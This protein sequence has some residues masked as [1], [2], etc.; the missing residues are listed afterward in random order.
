MTW[1]IWPR[2]LAARR[3]PPRRREEG[4][5]GVR[6]GKEGRVVTFCTC[7]TQNPSGGQV[8]DRGSGNSPGRSV[9]C[10]PPLDG[11]LSPY[12]PSPCCHV[13]YVCLPGRLRIRSP[14]PPGRHETTKHFKAA[15]LPR[16]PCCSDITSPAVFTAAALCASAAHSSGSACVFRSQGRVG[17][18]GKV[19]LLALQQ[20]KKMRG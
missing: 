6:K 9:S 17:T 20:K 18:E 7:R 19:Y 14:R 13:V 2:A 8:A 5:E 3:S 4:M 12:P 11:Y 10:P 15:L 16:V 1:H